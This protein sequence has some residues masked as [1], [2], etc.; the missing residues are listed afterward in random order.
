M[1]PRE[2]I[3]ALALVDLPINLDRK[4][5]A[6]FKEGFG[7]SW[8]YLSCECDD[9]YVDI[10]EELVR[11]CS[12]TQARSLCLFQ[13]DSKEIVLARATPKC[14][15]ILLRALRVIGRFEFL[16]SV[17]IY[18][19]TDLDVAAF[20]ALDFGTPSDASPDGR[21][22]LLRCYTSEDN[23]LHKVRPDWISLPRVKRF[24][25][26]FPPLDHCIVKAHG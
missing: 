24:S 16:D 18:S 7:A 9:F 2:V 10:V 1:L 6:S 21:R 15:N 11:L 26:F 3:L 17:P 25:P 19:E 8:C 20:N 22:V 4:H 5:D 23:F 14:R 12:F 13:S